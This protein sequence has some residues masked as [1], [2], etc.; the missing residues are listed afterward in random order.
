MEFVEQ[1]E[2]KLSSC[3][4]NCT[5][6]PRRI[7]G[8]T[9]TIRGNG[10]PDLT[11]LRNDEASSLCCELNCR[12]KGRKQSAHLR[13]GGLADLM[14]HR[15]QFIGEEVVVVRIEKEGKDHVLPS[16]LRQDEFALQLNTRW[17]Y[18]RRR[19]ARRRRPEVQLDR[20]SHQPL[21]FL[22]GRE[23]LACSC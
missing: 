3:D 4:D 20:S 12:W 1:G 19:C 5:F 10:C 16:Q 18:W 6:R 23:S 8:P 2:T 7:H 15:A 22:Q 11:G 21:L 13:L 14:D 9:H 17:R